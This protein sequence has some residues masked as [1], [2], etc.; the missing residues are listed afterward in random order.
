MPIIRY[1]SLCRKTPNM[2]VGRPLEQLPSVLEGLQIQVLKYGRSS[3][4]CAPELE[5]ASY[6][7]KGNCRDS[8]AAELSPQMLW[9]SINAFPGAL[10]HG[11]P[12][13]RCH[14]TMNSKN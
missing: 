8:V 7:L 14:A 1:P 2:E 9:D 4:G 12:D 13:M 3:F 6:G 11:R 5:N 10:V